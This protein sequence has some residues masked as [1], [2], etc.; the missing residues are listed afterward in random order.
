MHHR[1]VVGAVGELQPWLT[2]AGAGCRYLQMRYAF[3]NVDRDPDGMHANDHGVSLAL[4]QK[5][6]ARDP[7][8]WPPLYVSQVVDVLRCLREHFD[9]VA[10]V[11]MMPEQDER[12]A[13]QRAEDTSPRT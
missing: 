13:K 3:G 10:K 2:I 4:A 1:G 8:D 11:P 7:P 12:L 9:A 6:L 5:A